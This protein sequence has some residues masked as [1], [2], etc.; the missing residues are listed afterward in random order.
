MIQ[1]A[2][3]STSDTTKA[4]NQEIQLDQKSERVKARSFFISRANFFAL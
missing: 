3:Q 1:E 2:E 4:C